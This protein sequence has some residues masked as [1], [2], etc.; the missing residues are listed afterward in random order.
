MKDLWKNSINCPKI[1]NSLWIPNQLNNLDQ[2]EISVLSKGL[3]FASNY[4]PKDVLQ[5]IAQIE[6]VVE[7]LKKRQQLRKIQN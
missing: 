2:H 3:N 5:F 6:Q 1:N 4:C 7:D